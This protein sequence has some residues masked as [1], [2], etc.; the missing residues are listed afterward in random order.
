MPKCNLIILGFP[1]SG[2]SSL[3]E[4]LALHPDICMSR[5]KE[6]QFFSISTQWERGFAW[7]DSLFEDEGRPRRWYGESSQSY[8]GW[9]PAL[10]RIKAYLEEPRFIVLLR[11]PVD[12]LI[13]HYRWL[14]AMDL[15]SRPILKAVQEEN[16]KK[17]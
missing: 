1:K 3:H 8:S 14:W 15:E 5:E 16:K 10:Q 6:P 9:E 13:S 4:Y 17:R 11:H 2:T 7:Y 12:R